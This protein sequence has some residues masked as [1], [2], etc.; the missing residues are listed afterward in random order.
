MA[1]RVFYS[2]QY[3]TDHWRASQIRNIGV[4][5]GNRPVTDNDWETVTKGKDPA[6][7]RWIRAQMRGRSCTV[8]LIGAT[9]A[10]RKW[11]DFEI[12]ESWKARLGVLGI[13]I[14]NLN[15]SLGKQATKGANPFSAFNLNGKALT[16]I[17]KTYDPPFTIS[18]NVYK[19]I[20]ENLE[21]WVDAAIEIR[22]AHK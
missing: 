16:S 10:G 7:E 4:V 21:D 12:E 11:I 8:V 17:I 18:T 5:D 1:R 3:K 13:H 20:S 15:N 2:F 9:T 14:H 6:I 22:E 19:H